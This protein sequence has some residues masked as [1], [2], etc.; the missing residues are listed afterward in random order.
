MKWGR[1]LVSR[2]LFRLVIRQLYPL[3]HEEL[4]DNLWNVL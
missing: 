4:Q 1:G 2:L 3:K